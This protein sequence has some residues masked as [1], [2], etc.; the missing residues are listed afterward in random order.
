MNRDFK[1]FFKYLMY[2]FEY[3]RSVNYYGHIKNN[4]KNYNSLE[5]GP[6]NAKCQKKNLYTKVNVI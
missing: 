1:I 3:I 4:M 2:K 6:C 5:E